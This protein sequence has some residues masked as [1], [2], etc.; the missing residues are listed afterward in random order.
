MGGWRR[1]SK[2]CF[3][4][5][6]KQKTFTPAV[7]PR[8]LQGAAA[9]RLFSKG[10]LLASVLLAG[11][12][13]AQALVGARDPGLYRI[14]GDQDRADP[15]TTAG[16][17][18]VGGTPTLLQRTTHICARLHTSFGVRFV[19]S[20]DFGTDALPVD[21]A[22]LHPAMPNHAGAQQDADHTPSML[23]A[24]QPHFYG[25]TFA[26]PARLVPGRWHITLSHG[27]VMLLDQPFDIDFACTVPIA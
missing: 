9:Q 21:V 8:T 5:E 6:Q 18:S 22:V 25:W 11:P 26:D 17:R 20:R 1:R 3:F 7:A 27:G 10:G 16:V 2:A 14:D 13:H 12:A 19:L 15:S 23:Q 4:L 24:G